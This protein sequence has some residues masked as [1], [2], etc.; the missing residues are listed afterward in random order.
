[1]PNFTL[2]D[3]K[4]NQ[5]FQNSSPEQQQS[6]LQKYTELSWNETSR[7]TDYAFGDPTTQKA[8]EDSFAQSHPF[9]QEVISQDKHKYDTTSDNII[10][11]LGTGAKSLINDFGL[12]DD[13]IT[14]KSDGN[15]ALN[16]AEGSKIQQESYTSPEE[17][18]LHT[19]IANIDKQFNAAKTLTDKMLALGEG[20]INIAS[21]PA[22]ILESGAKS[23]AYSAPPIIGGIV[24]A[25]THNAKLAEDLTF[26][27]EMTSEAGAALQQRADAKLDNLKLPHTKENYQK[28]IDDKNIWNTLI[29]GSRAKSV[30]TATTSTIFSEL[31]G[32]IGSTS[33]RAANK[34][35]IK[36]VGKDASKEVFNKEF[37]KQAAKI[38]RTSKIRDKALAYVSDVLG[39]GGSEAAG[40]AASGNKF[41]LSNT[42]EEM[43]GAI[44]AGPITTT[45]SI[46]VFGTKSLGKT[47]LKAGE[48]SIT[49]FNLRKDAEVQ[50][51]KKV[52]K[53]RTNKPNYIKQVNSVTDI[54]E[55]DKY[56]DPSNPDTYDPIRAVDIIA[57]ISKDPKTTEAVRIANIAKAKEINRG[58]VKDSEAKFAEYNKLI[59][60]EQSGEKLTR[61]E[62]KRR[63]KLATLI[64]L[65]TATVS[66]ITD[67]IKDMN[68]DVE[69]SNADSITAL[70]TAVDNN[71]SE[72][73][74][75]NIVKILGSSSRGSDLSKYIDFKAIA[76]NP[77][78]TPEVKQQVANLAKLDGTRQ[79]FYKKASSSKKTIQD[80]QN[81]IFKGSHGFVGIDQRLSAIASAVESGDSKLAQSHLTGLTDLKNRQVAKLKLLKSQST[82]P[83]LLNAVDSEVKALNQAIVSAND[84]MAKLPSNKENVAKNEDLGAKTAS[85]YK[86]VTKIISGGQDGVDRAG[87]RVGKEL[88]IETGGTAPPKFVTSSHRQGDL[89]LRDKYNLTE[90]EADPKVYPKRT[91]ANVVNSDGTVLFGDMSSPG[92]RQTIQFL[93]KHNKPFI[94]NP[95]EKTL[96]TWLKDSNIETL[97]VAG[98]RKHKDMSIYQDTLKHALQ[99]NTANQTTETV[100]KFTPVSELSDKQIKEEVKQIADKQSK[101]GKISD[102]AKT[103][104]TELVNE[105]RKRNEANKSNSNSEKSST[106]IK[107][108]TKED[109]SKK[110]MFAYPSSDGTIL[111]RKDITVKEFTA[112]LH[113]E[114]KSDAAKLRREVLKQ[115]GLDINF[116]KRVLN[117]P[118]KIAQFIADSILNHVENFDND[119]SVYSDAEGAITQEKIN[120]EIRAS[121]AA[122]KKL[123]I[124]LPS[125][126]V[127]TKPLKNT[128]DLKSNLEDHELTELPDKSFDSYKKI[129]LVKLFGKLKKAINS[130][131]GFSRTETNLSNVTNN[132]ISKLN[133]EHKDTP[134]ITNLLKS[135]GSFS[136]EFSE[137]IN[138]IYQPS[139]QGY[140]YKSPIDYLADADGKLNPALV[141]A[142]I[143]GSYRWLA[144]SGQETSYNNDSNITSM[145]GLNN[146]SYLNGS[147]QFLRKVGTRE[148]LLY[149]SLG[150]EI[151]KIFGLSFDKA[152]VYDRATSDFEKSLGQL[153][154]TA[155][156]N[157]NY[158]HNKPVS[159]SDMNTAQQNIIKYNGKYSRDV[160]NGSTNSYPTTGVTKFVSINK[161]K[162]EQINK[163][164]ALNS[165]F[166][167]KL[168]GLEKT[169]NREYSTSKFI[170]PSDDYTAPIEK[171]IYRATKEQTKGL[172]KNMNHGYE[173]NKHLTDVL[174]ELPSDVVEYLA[175]VRDISTLQ[176]DDRDGAEASNESIRRSL[177][178]FN[179]HKVIFDTAKQI[180]IPQVIDNNGRMRQVGAFQ[181]QNFKPHRSLLSLVDAKFTFK[182]H[183]G[184]KKN[185]GLQAFKLAIAQ[186]LGMEEYKLGGRENTLKLFNKRMKS[187]VIKSG[188]KAISILSDK[189]ALSNLSEEEKVTLYNQ[190]Q[191]AVDEGGEDLHSLHGL[192][193]YQKFLEA[194][195]SK[196]TEF[197]TNITFESDGTTDGPVISILQFMQSTDYA[198]NRSI[199]EAGGYY[200]DN[201]EGNRSGKQYKDAYEL[202]GVEFVKNVINK[203]KKLIDLKS[204][205]K[206]AAYD[207]L[208]G[209]LQEDSPDTRKKVKKAIPGAL[210]G[211]G[212][213]QMTN[214]IV[215]ELVIKNITKKIANAV[216]RYHEGDTNAKTELS[217][218]RKQVNILAGYNGDE[219]RSW[220]YTPETVTEFLETE[221]PNTVKLGI[222]NFIKKEHGKSLHEAVH[223]VYKDIKEGTAPLNK[224]F[225]VMAAR[226]N[227][228]YKQLYNNLVKE[229]EANNEIITEQDILDL[230]DKLAPLRPQI[231][232][233]LGQT[234]VIGRF[235]PSKHITG[236]FNLEQKYT[237]HSEILS[238]RTNRD[239][240]RE[241]AST[242]VNGPVYATHSL[243]AATANTLM[244]LADYGFLNTHDGETTGLANT[245]K[246]STSLNKTM[247]E[248]QKNYSISEASLNAFNANT[249]YLKSLGIELNQDDLLTTL[250]DLSIQNIE[251]DNIQ[252]HID[253]NIAEATKFSETNK[254]VKENFLNNILGVNHYFHGDG[255]HE[256]NSSSVDEKSNVDSEENLRKLGSSRNNVSTDETDYSKAT[257][258][259]QQNVVET[260]ES[261][262]QVNDSNPAAKQDSP[263]HKAYLKHINEK[264]LSAV[265]K[266]VNLFL[267]DVTEST[268]EG[269]ILI[270]KKGKNKIF[271]EN[272]VP[273]ATRASGILNQ[274]I[275]MSLGE[276]FTHETVHS[277]IS[278]GLM[279]K[280]RLARKV[281]KIYNFVFDQLNKDEEGYKVFLSDPNLDVSDPA[282]KYEVQAAKNRYAFIFSPR[283]SDS[284]ITEEKTSNHLDEFM[285]HAIS[286]EHFGKY[287]SNLNFDPKLLNTKSWSDIF[288]GNLQEIIL[289]IFDKVLAGIHDKFGIHKPTSNTR[290]A[291]ENLALELGHA[292][293]RHK[294]ALFNMISTPVDMLD[295]TYK[296]IAKK[297]N[298]I[299]FKIYNS[300]PIVQTARML[301]QGVLYAKE[302]DTPLGKQLREL[303]EKWHSKKPGFIKA[304][305]QDMH[306][307][308]E[309]TQPLYDLLN[310]KNELVDKKRL[311]IT[312]T[313]KKFLDHLYKDHEWKD[314]EKEAY[315]KVGLKLDIESLRKFNSIDD[316]QNYLGSDRVLN[317]RISE[318]EN[319]IKSDPELKTYF[320]YFSKASESLGYFMVHSRGALNADPLLN[321]DLIANLANTEFEDILSNQAE[322]KVRDIVDQLA[323]LY[324]IKHSTGKNRNLLKGVISADPEAFNAVMSLH[325]EL[326]NKAKNE[327]FQVSDAKFIKGYTKEML[328]PYIQVDYGTLADEQAFKERGLFRQKYPI[329][330]D[331][332]DKFSEEIY[333]YSGEVG[334][335]NNLVPSLVSYSNFSKKGV[336]VHNIIN[337]Q[338]TNGKK[339]SVTA[340]LQ[341]IK[342]AKAKIRES[343]FKSDPLVFPDPGDN[344][345]IASV[346]DDGHIIDYRYVAAE[347]TKD[348][349]YQQHHGFDDIMASMAGSIE[350]KVGSTKINRA[351][352]SALKDFKDNNPDVP[353]SA[354]MNIGPFSTDPEGIEIYQRLPASTKKEITRVWHTPSMKI[355]KDLVNLIF[356]Y[357]KYSVVDMFGKTP[358]ERNFVEKALVSTS[359]FIIGNDKAARKLKSIEDL[360]SYLAKQ[361]KSAIVIKSLSITMGNNVSNLM[362][363]RSRGVTRKEMAQYYTEATTGAYSYLAD[364]TKLNDLKLKKIVLEDTKPTANKS[365]QSINSQLRKVNNQIVDME[366]SI[367]LN[368]VS[369]LIE[370]GAMQ[371]L[372][373][374]VNTAKEANIFS[375]GPEAFV[376]NQVNKLPGAIQTIGRNLFMTED[377]KHFRIANN[378]VKMTDFVARYTLYKHYVDVEKSMKHDEAVSSVIREFI[379]FNIPSHRMLEYA[380]QIGF[381]YFTKYQLRVLRSIF[382]SVTKKP[383]ESLTTFMLSHAMGASNIM[384]SIPF[385]TKNV[386][387]LFGDPLSAFFQ[388]LW[389]IPS[390]KPV[391]S[392]L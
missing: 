304:V 166:A 231:K 77:N 4:N 383:F 185:E 348:E 49:K 336:S 147:I 267:K 135:L 65:N 180:Y 211:A 234:V 277:I 148:T 78:I 390:L 139:K 8:I 123:G 158:L 338:I 247:Y 220:R 26:A 110:D 385:V 279:M 73:I 272:Q 154:L 386:M 119:V 96:R 29:F 343:M 129:N 36:I 128:E 213:D 71:D 226:Y 98:N 124:A 261:F 269:V 101:D 290:T 157:L 262:Q 118:S 205:A 95:T 144:T 74:S 322:N 1:M 357:R 206:Y 184:N 39:E 255:F 6:L 391:T 382:E 57:N 37:I 61:A 164:H 60:K 79:S 294:S 7:S 130:F 326:K 245:S 329:P 25:A 198:A 16:L 53:S 240:Q 248:V 223:S 202:I 275:R 46:G 319:Q 297:A 333:M 58:V 208:A 106:K 23:L 233:A 307:A 117:T 363:L 91:E 340:S 167:T 174:S 62:K 188:L 187:D 265:M 196:N 320:N 68:N 131:I 321:A 145:L 100:N 19:N 209:E 30:V 365:Q 92:S 136:T 52:A 225:L 251:E 280:P 207:Y 354:Y 352:V 179:L 264:I 176:I 263:E 171:S 203:I 388:S 257:E 344:S 35:T 260:Y 159:N 108:V 116:I 246:M 75:N 80:V 351:V 55:A 222:Y 371:S 17:R 353:N 67:T 201:T 34:A 210:Y 183:T 366:N 253:N 278:H 292:D 228:A 283:R 298:N 243:D 230:R 389:L 194:K 235:A 346:D 125:E 204:K 378:L 327:L 345:M 45:A 303:T 165:K 104:R 168:F 212:L 115:M 249:A 377:T 86:G 335:K 232:N 66:K 28:L 31:T 287:L 364:T 99:P 284:V 356:G 44:G 40:E 387:M 302:S 90:G 314:G 189:T 112:D 64:Q 250:A 69:S 200:S 259:N 133:P 54:S 350:D 56:S 271:I 311:T 24:G 93:K 392:L 41:S 81:D 214:G 291:L 238:T 122:F 341:D 299:I 358:K 219:S 109:M 14:G 103:R 239:S 384:E 368:P 47:A 32:L 254:Q 227:E 285:A 84:L 236:E 18:K 140:N 339:I 181:T 163:N 244:Q 38:S 170:R 138:K 252:E 72:G 76:N 105:L 94:V 156:T 82:A 289:D 218:I 308:S 258:I 20:A 301:R 51:A 312:Q 126:Q 381:M 15:T 309:R 355:R 241:L 113:D 380:N 151:N 121:K 313:Y 300:L 315:H 323:T 48:H 88:G 21:N 83:V 134:K 318:L 221:I 177:A 242:R 369:K 149:D 107:Y 13:V 153:A 120:I 325:R 359:Q 191:K 43:V 342:K 97:N 216:K 152:N 306:G 172:Y 3:L 85:G 330:K 270:T 50:Q 160:T 173:E 197:T 332:N 42:I 217:E 132:L 59:E 375:T 256:V 178:S 316:I 111:V 360:A 142:I 141:N 282:N 370:A 87:L 190:L 224:L 372:I 143:M 288:K 273:G 305:I 127:N 296:K 310:V 274:G 161:E 334:V 102:E 186:S 169:D 361:A 155:L 10:N 22:G 379:D 337:N 63:N 162:T 9:G 347:S 268:T 193:E 324:G 146:N 89:S 367:A 362:Y 293:I 215:N 27:G 137:E 192:I 11:A 229:K 328:N 12:L 70:K 373:D 295:T 374:D 349:I 5:S 150:Q 175:G 281:R 266:P 376:N 2:D 182:L 199:L 33:T 331:K 317:D 276:V 237:K 114:V 195:S 286:N